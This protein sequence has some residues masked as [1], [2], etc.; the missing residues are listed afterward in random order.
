MLESAEIVSTQNLHI[1]HEGAGNYYTLTE[2]CYP[3]VPPPK[4][5]QDYHPQN[6]R[7]RAG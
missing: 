2:F 4:P 5:A 3:D 6:D 1:G 7:V